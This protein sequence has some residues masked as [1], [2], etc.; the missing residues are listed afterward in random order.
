MYIFPITAHYKVPEAMKAVDWIVEALEE[1][2][3]DA[4]NKAD[5][6]EKDKEMS[7]AIQNRLGRDTDAL[8][9]EA[10]R[11]KRGK[12]MQATETSPKANKEIHLT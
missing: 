10:S 2:R 8:K 1:R 11:L 7:T 9:I 12:N 4:E 5:E 3:R 6:A